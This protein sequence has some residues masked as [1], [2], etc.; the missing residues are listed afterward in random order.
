MATAGEDSPST[1]TGT[2]LSTMVPLPSLPNSPA[3]QHLT[4]PEASRAQVCMVP[5]PTAMT[6]EDRPT[7]STGT[8]LWIWEPSPSCPLSLNP[9]H[10]TPPVAS[11]AHACAPVTVRA[12]TPDE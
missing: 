2:A 4:A 9:Q 10:L 5:A 11:R 1:S 3:P 8:P 12:T 7:T 6:P